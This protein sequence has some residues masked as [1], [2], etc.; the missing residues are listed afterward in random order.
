MGK[1]LQDEEKNAE[2][3][4]G[5]FN[6]RKAKGKVSQSMKRFKVA[7][8]NLEKNYNIF[9]LE[10]NYLDHN[11]LIFVGKF[12][13]GLLFCIVSFIWWIHIILYVLV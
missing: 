6:K 11:P 1:T 3:E 10:L 13:L 2:V 9:K 12:I 5:F 7:V 4:T 8:F